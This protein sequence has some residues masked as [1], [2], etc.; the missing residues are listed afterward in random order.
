MAADS[1]SE[2]LVW[3]ERAEVD[4]DN[5]QSLAED[6]ADSPN[7]LWLIQ[8]AVEKGIKAVLIRE[9]INYPWSHDLQQLRELLPEDSALKNDPPSLKFLTQRALETRYPGE[10]D[11]ITP[12]NLAEGLALGSRFMELLKSSFPE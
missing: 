1:H 2:A 6:D 11:P 4:W 12:A 5:A 3:I 9:G 8:Q 7:V 10:Y